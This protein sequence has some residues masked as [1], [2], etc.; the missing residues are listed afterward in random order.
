MN[1]SVL[2]DV[3]EF[4]FFRIPFFLF[5]SLY[6]WCVILRF[7]FFPMSL[8]FGRLF[9]VIF[10][11]QIAGSYRGSNFSKGGIVLANWPP[12][13]VLLRVLSRVLRIM[14]AIGRCQGAVQGCYSGY[15][16]SWLPLGGVRVLSRDHVCH[17]AVSG[18]YPGC[19]GSCLPLGGVRVLLRGAVQ[20]A[21]DVVRVL[22]IMIAIGR[23]QGAVQGSPDHVCHW[24]VSGCC[25][26]APDHVCHWAVSGRGAVQGCCS[27]CYGSCLPLGG[28]RVPSRVL[29]RMLRIM[30]AIGRCQGAVEGCCPRCSG[31]CLPWCCPAVLSTF[32]IGWCQGVV[33]GAVQGA[34]QVLSRVLRIMFAIGRCQGAVQGAVHIA[35]DHVCHWAVSGC[36]PGCSGSCLPLGCPRCSGSR[37][38]LG[39]VRVLLRVLSRVLSRCCAG[40]CRGCSGSCDW[41]V[42]GCCARD[43]GSKAEPEFNVLISIWGLCW[44]NL[45]F[46]LGKFFNFG[47]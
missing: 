30:F 31:S 32:A 9:L 21:P 5:V 19:S 35:P 4:L 23:C 45:I 37:L 26:G 40:W 8:L 29:S 24:A 41:A 3:F 15:S 12:S 17:W 25:Q 16:G 10:F 42:S 2:G 1:S 43:K 14:F 18:C 11:H 39:D 13:R 7:S 44:C 33:E 47:H 36:C 20:G 28:V 34:V 27:G 46:A 38:L 22:R 6:F